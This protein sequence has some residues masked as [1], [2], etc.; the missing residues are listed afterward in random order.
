M[1]EK[2]FSGAPSF[3]PSTAKFTRRDNVLSAN[4]SAVPRN[5]RRSGSY[6]TIVLTVVTVMLT[7]SSGLGGEEPASLRILVYVFRPVFKSTMYPGC[8]IAVVLRLR[9]A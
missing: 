1:N 5:H 2:V 6:A 3:L 4:I 7:S 9:W 8:E